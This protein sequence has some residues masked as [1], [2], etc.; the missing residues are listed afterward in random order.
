MTYMIKDCQAVCIL[1]P[2]NFDPWITSSQEDVRDWSSE[3]EDE[4]F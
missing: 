4:A 1:I 3:T 2:E